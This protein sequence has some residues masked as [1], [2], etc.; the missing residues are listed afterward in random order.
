MRTFWQKK[1]IWNNKLPTELDFSMWVTSNQFDSSAMPCRRAIGFSMR[2]PIHFDYP[3]LNAGLT[4]RKPTL[5]VRRISHS[6][7]A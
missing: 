1:S 4:L 3:R 7:E 2:V 5:V 6:R